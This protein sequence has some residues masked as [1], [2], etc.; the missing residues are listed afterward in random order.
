MFHHA[1][2]DHVRSMRNLYHPVQIV[3]GDARTFQTEDH[4]AHLAPVQFG[5]R[6]NVV[7]IVLERG[8]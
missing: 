4:A 1:P 3:G 2:L 8:G 6:T 5:V 7:E